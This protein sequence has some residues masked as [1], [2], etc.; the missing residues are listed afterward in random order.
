MYACIYNLRAY[1]CKNK[2]KPL[3]FSITVRYNFVTENYCNY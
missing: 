2:G 3:F 1:R